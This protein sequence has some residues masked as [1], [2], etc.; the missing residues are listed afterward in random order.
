MRSRDISFIRYYILLQV[1]ILVGTRKSR[2]HHWVSFNPS[3]TVSYHTIIF[4]GIG[5]PVSPPPL[6]P[7]PY[8]NP[9]Q[10][11]SLSIHNMTTPLPRPK[12]QKGWTY[13]APLLRNRKSSYNIRDALHEFHQFHHS[14]LLAPPRE[15][16]LTRSQSHNSSRDVSPNSQPDHSAERERTHRSHVP[17]GLAFT[18]ASPSNAPKS[19]SPALSATRERHDTLNS[20]PETRASKTAPNSPGASPTATRHAKN[21]N[22][23]L[24]DLRRFLNHHIGH[25][26]DKES[27]NRSDSANHA[28]NQH[29]HDTSGPST[30]GVGPSGAATPGGQLRG[31]GFPGLTSATPSATPS[32]T[33]TGAQT[34]S[35]SHSD[36]NHVGH[37][38]HLM[39]F[40]R[41]HLKD[42]EGEKSHSSLAN[43]F[44]H[45]DKKK[46]RKGSKTPTDSRTTS[47]APSRQSTQLLM[48]EADTHS[49][50]HAHQPSA[51]HSPSITPSG[52]PGIATP[53][54]AS[55]YPGVPYPVVALSHPS[56]HEASHAH[57]SKKYG[58]WGKVLGSGAG[59][60]VRLIKASSKQGGT[61]YAVKEFRPR[62]QGE[63][64]K[65]YQR[66]VT[67]EFCVGVT[68]RH[69][70]VIE[71]VDIVNDHGHF[72][73]VS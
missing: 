45:G 38:N 47:A 37:S 35:D 27:K 69:V 21:H 62:R 33:T 26:G 22:G 2:T 31:A 14:L 54:N 16:E 58:K 68:L 41:H 56:L 13:A 44:G 55:D 19:G 46:D 4:L 1:R 73:E 5:V 10:T 59:G 36:R 70:N 48:T 40:M 7:Y 51:P 64:E 28:L 42:N 34:P 23:P 72:Y 18:P 17:S 20:I 9:C 15:P 52:T 66:K 3:T 61:T 67:A 8:P 60:T 57:L 11:T 39:G 29:M 30:P 24:H 63:N 32:R 43:F 12:A 65:E 50:T 6:C 25:H 53:K 71:T 49:H